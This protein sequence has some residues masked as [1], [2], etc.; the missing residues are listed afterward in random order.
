[1]QRFLFH[2]FLVL[3]SCSLGLPLSGLAQTITVGTLSP[4]AVC[5]GKATVISVP[6]TTTGS[7]G[8]TNTFTA[9]L[10]DASGA[11]SSS[12][13]NIGTLTAAS[14]ATT[15]TTRTISATILSGV[16]AGTGY[17][18]RVISS[19]APVKTSSNTAGLTISNTPSAP[20]VTSLPV[21]YCIGETAVP[22]SASP[23][24]G[25]TLNW[26]TTATGGTP[27]SIAPTPDTKQADTLQYYVSQM[28]GTCESARAPLTVTVNGTPPAPSI[29]SSLSLSFCRGATLSPLTATAAAGAT[30]RWYGTTASGGTFSSTAPI[31]DNQNSATY[32][33][34][35]ARGKCES[36]RTAI[37]VTILSPSAPSVV[38]PAASYCPGQTAAPLSATA[39]TG[40]TLNWY[41]TNSTGGTSSST[42]TVPSTTSSGTYYVSQTV[43]N[44]ESPRASIS[45]TVKPTPATPSVTNLSLCQNRSAN[46]LTASGVTGTI[47]WYSPNSSTPSTTAPTPSVTATGATSFSVSQTVNDCESS[48]A[49]LTVTVNAVPAMPTVAA[50]GPTY[51]QGA[52]AQPLSATGTALLWYGANQTGSTGNSTATVPLT[53]STG[54]TTYYVTQTTN[55]C[56]SDRAGITVT[57]KTTPA[58]PDAINALSFCQNATAL[59]GLTATPVT[60][61]TLLWYGASATGGTSTTVTPTLSSSTVGTTNYYVSQTLDGCESASRSAIAVTVKPTPEIPT[62]TAVAYCNNEK[63]QQLT[64]IGNAIKWY[65]AAG[66]ALSGAPTPPTGAVG[67]QTYQATQTVDGCESQQKAALT[68][69]IKPLPGQPGVANL[70]YCQ[71]T[72][73]QPA[74]NV[75]PLTASGDNLRWYNTDGNPFQ[76]APTPPVTQVGTYT[77][78]V[79]QTV[80]GC[81]GGRA[82]L[83]VAVN[84]TPAPTVTTPLVTYCINTTAAPLQATAATGASLRWINPYNN[85]SVEAP[86][87]STLNSNVVAGGDPFY[88]YQI[89]SNGCYSSRA[90]IRVVVNVAPTLALNGAGEVNLGTLAP[91]KLSF[92]GAPPFSYTLTDGYSGISRTNDTTIYVLPRGNTTYQIVSV[93]N[94]CGVGLPG[95]PA[96][97]TITVRVPV[98][99]TSALQ[100][101][102]VCAGS[103]FAVPF[104]TTGQFTAGNLFTA[105]L[106]SVADTSRKIRV[107]PNGTTGSVVTAVTPL[108]LTAGQYY[109]RVKGSNPSVGITGSNSPSILTVRARATATL[110]GTQ[111]IYEGS[112]ATLTLTFGGEAPWTA[113]YADSLRSYTVTAASSPY[114]LEVLPARATTYR[115]TGVSN[116]CGVGTT[117][118]GSAVVTVQKVLGVEDP[119]LGPL[120][121]I[122]PVPTGATLTVD[123]DVSLLRDPAILTLHDASGRPVL[124]QT[125]RSRQTTLDVNQQPAGTY[126]LR[127]QIGDRQLVRRI[128][129][130]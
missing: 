68:V 113:T 115:L 130:Q 41:G 87:P 4:A 12:A 24:N 98:I 25:A 15:A 104:T 2:C 93:A 122:Y 67:T 14:S 42:A 11:F 22:L 61:A 118:S 5:T 106:V 79:S 29:P 53:S 111:S 125:T 46:A 62:V 38:S 37:S 49:T 89:G 77:Y 83:Q 50:T 84:S 55:G 86:T 75:G 63:S 123:I 102:T 65:D 109:V 7:F 58:Q 10:S 44:C 13:T 114:T 51:C 17:Q 73:D 9:Q 119:S 76:S 31:P 129:K 32:Y 1:M 69:T 92:T 117:V 72:Q 26:Y 43:G 34:S 40:G 90:T 127:I 81:E 56:V 95:N 112:P 39:S 116:N 99:T 48:K 23:V 120:V 80:N 74:Q 94:S 126:L 30:L 36:S 57:V 110:T 96:T 100:T 6:F 19:T 82:T 54:P 101:S 64:A 78:Q 71:P 88:V 45:V 27:S 108:T 16:A 105:E 3:V 124:N 66:T 97:A 52:S 20:G 21:A 91:V 8:S 128:L 28:L 59:P 33:V 35:Q 107:S 60:G 85:T 70:S 121:N 47:N 18:V 103:S